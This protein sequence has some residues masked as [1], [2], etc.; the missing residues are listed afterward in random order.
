[1]KDLQKEKEK[2]GRTSE[3]FYVFIWCLSTSFDM[4]NFFLSLA[5][6]RGVIDLLACTLA[7]LKYCIRSRD[8][9]RLGGGG[10]YIFV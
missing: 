2:R 5:F 8:I 7:C 9:T 10:F 6:L 1:M 3:S 4:E